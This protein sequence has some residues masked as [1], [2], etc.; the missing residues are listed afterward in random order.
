MLL[1]L[2]AV[3][4]MSSASDASGN[5]S[6]EDTD[7]GTVP[8]YTCHQCNTR[9]RSPPDNLLKAGHIN[10][11]ALLDMLSYLSHSALLTASDF[12]ILI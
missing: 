10:V 9:S 7:Q 4:E 11:P 3:E 1:F 5:E 12:V 8:G 2:F 6:Y